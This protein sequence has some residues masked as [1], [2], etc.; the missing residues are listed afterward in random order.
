[1]TTTREAESIEFPI[2]IIEG[3][4][5]AY[6]RVGRRTDDGRKVSRITIT[7]DMN[8]PHGL[9]ERYRVFCGDDLICEGPMYMLQSTRYAK[10]EKADV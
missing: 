3:E 10:P 5:G 1:M 8:G 2:A 6:Y 7:E 9:L 4:Y